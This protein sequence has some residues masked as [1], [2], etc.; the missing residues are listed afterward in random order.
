MSLKSAMKFNQ[1]MEMCGR[2][3]QGVYSVEFKDIYIWVQN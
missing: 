3:L 2:P 1:K